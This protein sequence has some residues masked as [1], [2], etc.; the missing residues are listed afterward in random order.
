MAK[1]SHKFFQP[2]WWKVGGTLRR[3]TRTEL[4]KRCE[5]T[6]SFVKANPSGGVPI[7]PKHPSAGSIDGGPRL[8]DRDARDNVGWLEGC[9]ID[10]KGGCWA[11]YDIADKATVDGLENGTIRFTSP[12][13]SAKNY[14]DRSGKDWG[15]MFRHMAMTPAPANRN[16]GQITPMQFDEDCIQFCEED[17]MGTTKAEAEKKAAQFAD[18]EDKKETSPPTP[19]ADKQPTNDTEVTVATDNEDDEQIAELVEMLR[20]ETGIELPGNSSTRDL[21]IALLNMVITERRVKTETTGELPVTEEAPQQF[22]DEA[23]AVINAKDEQIRAMQAKEQ[24]GQLRTRRAKVSAAISAARMPPRAKALLATQATDLQ[25]SDEGAEE[26]RFTVQQVIS[27]FEDGMPKALQFDDTDVKDVAEEE[28]PD[29]KQFFDP[30]ND[31]GE[32]TDEQADAAA[33]EQLANAGYGDGGFSGRTAKFSRD[34]S[35]AATGGATATAQ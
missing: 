20:T 32:E 19:N 4:A 7:F 33:A 34:Y 26:P 31:T 17:F 13:F 2:G 12:E 21:L 35:D 8:R 18:D 22:S 11:D 30:A 3:F 16:Q 15:P 10:S 28:H 27:I 6:D 9:R 23:Q 25:F 1:Y 24:A 5:N 14:E 29:G